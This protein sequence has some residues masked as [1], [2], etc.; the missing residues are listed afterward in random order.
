[1]SYTRKQSLNAFSFIYVYLVSLVLYTKGNECSELN[2][3]RTHYN[4]TCNVQL[5]KHYTWRKR[6]NKLVFHKL[7]SPT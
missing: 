7:Q 6:E 1:M 3:K 5:P 2:E 4:T